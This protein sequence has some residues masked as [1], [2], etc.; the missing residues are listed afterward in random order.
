MF[1]NSCV[2]T[3]TSKTTWSDP[4]PYI[5]LITY[6]TSCVLVTVQI[7]KYQPIRLKGFIVLIKKTN[8]FLQS[9]MWCR[10]VQNI[11]SQLEL[12]CK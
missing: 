12:I 7:C 11:I 9:E 4:V 2:N 8:G 3:V 10:V 1:A 6:H 5:H